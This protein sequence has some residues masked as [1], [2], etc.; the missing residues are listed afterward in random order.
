M[1]KTNNISKEENILVKILQYGVYAVA[2]IPLVIFS[3]Y[4]S[5][6][7]FGKVVVFRSIIEILLV[8]YIILL[9]SPGG[10]EKYLPRKSPI[11][12]AFVIFAAVFG[13]ASLTSINPFQSFWGTLER[14]GG[15]F[16]FMHY[17][18][19]F[20]ILTSVFRDRRDWIRLINFAL[21]VSVLSAFYGYLQKTDIDWVIGSGGRS[22]IFGTIGNP[23]LFAGYMI[24]SAFLSLTMF[25]SKE[26]TQKSKRFY[27]AVFLIDSLAIFLT[28]IRGSVLGWVIGIL[29]FGFASG[30]KKL[31]NL[32]LYFMIF[33]IASAATL[34]M[35]R[36]ADFVK[37]NQ[38]LDRYADISPMTYTV[39]TRTWAWAAG[40]DGWNDSAKSMLVGYGPENF[41]YP[42]SFHF[43]PKFYAGPGSE[44][45]FDR[46]HN[47]FIEI[48][49]TMGIVGLLAYLYLFVTAFGGLKRL[50]P[51]DRSYR[52][53]FIALIVAYMIHNSFIFDTSANF[54]AF[55]TVLGFIYFLDPK[56]SKT[57]VVER[58][59]RKPST[60]LGFLAVILLLAVSIVIYKVN[61]LPA[62][63]NYAATRAIV[64]SWG[65]DFDKS[66]K[67]YTEAMGYGVPGKYEIRH[68]FAKFVI[69]ASNTKDALSSPKVIDALELAI[70]EVEKNKKEN[71]D[72]YLPLLYL[73]RLHIMLG[74]NDP[75]SF[76]NDKAVEESLA[77][78][79]ISPTFVR[80]YF[81]VAQAYIN[82]K[83]YDTAIGYFEEAHELQPD[84]A[85]TSWY[86]GMTY[87]EMGQVQKGLK[88]LEDAGM[89]YN[90]TQ[91]LKMIDVYVGQ[92]NYPKVVE[93]YEKVVRQN[94]DNPQFHASL[95]VAYAQVG[96]IDQAV[97]AAQKAAELDPSFAAESQAF[98]DAITGG[99]Q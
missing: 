97:A 8:F 23:A 62:R 90:A 3:E 72:D 20:I 58:T 88:F 56:T 40:I 63:A 35:L 42:F 77:A 98:I 33:V 53:G 74:K 26:A 37:S 55:F 27:F 87:I 46:A 84:V 9:L 21:F 22:K 78:L 11:L 71:H 89:S 12:W 30:V 99:A 29:V 75:S 94:P 31:K 7:H 82:K 52:I 57:E 65:G 96:R 18:V 19:F 80:S 10:R 66:V 34:Y 93:L 25:F 4:L 43:N 32:T 59:E 16:T 81:E 5:P 38:Y 76:H 14:M 92:K 44:T 1:S 15:W 28:G 60:M 83:D 54:I 39:Q 86:L 70:Q 91:L 48:L 24:V 95:A 36:D 64:A 45:L 17:L 61:V 51:E 6:F 41:N 2:L 13:I 67:K 47:M 49:V 79:E 85:V 68:R 50:P 73:A 69:E